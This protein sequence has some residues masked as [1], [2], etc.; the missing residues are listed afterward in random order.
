MISELFFASSTPATSER[1][2]FWRTQKTAA[3]L[4]P[5]DSALVAAACIWRM[6][7]RNR[8]STSTGAHEWERRPWLASVPAPG[9]RRTRPVVDE[10]VA[11]TGGVGGSCPL[12]S[13]HR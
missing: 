2:L 5:N 10:A 9:R 12:P 7:I 4:L 1:H 6:K 3:L 13:S 8:P 11:L